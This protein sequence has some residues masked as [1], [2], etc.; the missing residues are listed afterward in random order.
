M[1]RRLL[2]AIGLLIA[3][4]PRSASAQDVEMLGRRY[5]KRPPDA[6]YDEL[7]RNPDAFRF[8]RGRSLRMREAAERRRLARGGGPADRGGA[9]DTANGGPVRVGPSGVGGPAAV[10][11]GPRDQP[12]V[13]DVHVP[14]VLGLFSD[15]PAT[16]PVARTTV[17][18]GYFGPQAGTVADFYAEVSNDSIA[19]LGEVRD[20]V[21]SSLSQAQATE[22]ISGLG[23]CGIGDYIKSLLDRQ[24]AGVDWG[25][26]DNDGPDG[27]PNSGDDDGYVDALAVIHP[28]AGAECPGDWPDRIWSHKWT[29][30]DASTDGG[31]Y[32]TG[33][34]A[35]GG[36]FILIEDYFVQGA[37][38]CSGSGLNDIGV[39]THELGHAF[40]LPDLYDTRAVGIAHDGA[41]SWELMA[42]GTYGCGNNTPDRPCHMGAW[43]KAMLGWVRVD[44]L[45]PDTDL[46]TLTLPPVE[47]SGIAYRV[48]AEDGSGEY[49]LMENRQSL[50][51]VYFDQALPAEGLLIWQIDQA[52]VDARWLLNTVNSFDHM[53]V[54]LRQADGLD[55]LG[56]PGGD[57]G[58][59]GDPFPGVT[60]NT[61]FHAATNPAAT[62]YQGTATGLTILDVTPVG[63]DLDF[64]LLTRFTRLTLTSSGTSAGA[65][66]LFTVDGATVPDAPDNFALSAPFV[67]RTIQAAAGDSVSPG[68]RT[69]FSQW[70]DDPAES[71]T[72]VVVTPL[73]DTTFN[74]TYSGTEYELRVDL[75]G[76]VNGVL[77]GSVTTTPPSA[78]LWFT[79]GTGVSVTAAAQTGFSFV[80]WTGDLSGQ[81]NPAS[82]TMDAPVF[83]G[84]DF[85]LIYGVPDTLVALVGATPV[86]LQLEVL[87]GTSPV[88]WF[89]Q[90]GTV[91][92]GV[93][94]GSDGSITGAALELGSYPLVLRAT[95]ALGLTAM[96]NVTLDVAAPAIPLARLGDAFF[97]GSQ[98]LDSLEEALLDRE[99]NDN[100]RYDLGDFRSWVLA[101]PSLPLSADLSPERGAIDKPRTIRLPVALEKPEEGL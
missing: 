35:A 83:G 90:G 101:Y 36:G 80:A 39:F 3:V 13:G 42:A 8:S 61:A 23:C 31:P 6:Y 88:V 38:K 70:D 77:P 25:T 74:A 63:D 93:V 40:G 94:V 29:L 58:D 4:S 1:Y 68:V 51:S 100:G 7:A 27:V 66:G 28:T 47:T 78:D 98:P 76:G 64:R 72:R 2:L 91:P 10:G 87:N 44:T 37:V 84:A 53:G 65:S 85:E 69:S 33:T 75:T 45:P 50:A 81:P 86:S 67:P 73:A 48:D 49:F 32:V 34:S 41:G 12:V 92:A 96:A 43:S 59:S 20:W 26:Y 79:P 5:G 52:A 56:T 95:D 30:S 82:V 21:R 19:L 16:P 57:R 99:G 46:G 11:L 62:S 18:D 55:E 17:Q 14:V 89:V 97:L 22:G 60:G 71:R 9:P 54:W 24:G 15:S